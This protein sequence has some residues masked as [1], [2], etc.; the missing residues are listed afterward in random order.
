MTHS[1]LYKVTDT[2]LVIEL[3]PGFRNKE[4]LVTVDDHPATGNDKIALMKQAAKD[5]LFLSDMNE[6]NEDFE[7]VEHDMP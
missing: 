3:P 4:V 2:K 7:G 6:V 5:P 1:R